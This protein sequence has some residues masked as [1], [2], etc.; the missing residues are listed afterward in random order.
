MAEIDFKITHCFSSV[1][2][3]LLFHHIPYA[4]HNLHVCS[5]QFM[6]VTYEN[7]QQFYDTETL[8]LVIISVC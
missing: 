1:V 2:L 7:V 6:F 3:N 4:L 5:K 8:I